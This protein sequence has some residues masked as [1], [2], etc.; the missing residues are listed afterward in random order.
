MFSCKFKW[1]E[2]VDHTNTE[3]TKQMDL[4]WLCVLQLGWL[5]NRFIYFLISRDKVRMIFDDNG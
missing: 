1:Y 5:Q 4:V 2:F 3:Q